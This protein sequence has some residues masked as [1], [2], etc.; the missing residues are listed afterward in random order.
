MSRNG[1]YHSDSRISIGG[2]TKAPLLSNP[3]SE[4]KLGVRTIHHAINIGATKAVT[5]KKP[6]KRDEK[7]PDFENNA[8]LLR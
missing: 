1:P 4:S 3:I 7:A 8:Y 6:I 5:T 2:D